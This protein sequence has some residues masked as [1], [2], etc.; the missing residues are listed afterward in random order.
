MLRIPA[1]DNYSRIY[2]EDKIVFCTIKV[3]NLDL[4][5]AEAMVSLRLSFTKKESFPIFIDASRVTSVSKE[6]RDF[7]SDKKA[8]SYVKAAAI[9]APSIIARILANFFLGFGKPNTP[10]R[11]FTTEKDAIV[12]LNNY[13]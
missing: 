8:T 6:A 2:L 1:E 12:W 10:T 3:K 13:K 7:F 11:V 4:K 5:T 9:L